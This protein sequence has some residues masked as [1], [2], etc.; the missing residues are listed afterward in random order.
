MRSW[1]LGVHDNAGCQP[2]KIC[3]KIWMVVRGIGAECRISRHGVV[4]R[5][6]IWTFATATTNYS[7][8][9]AIAS[10]NDDQ[11]SL[12]SGTL[13]NN[14][15]NSGATSHCPIRDFLSFERHYSCTFATC[16]VCDCDLKVVYLAFSTAGKRSS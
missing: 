4:R 16:S 5:A 3:V 6:A 1:R 9:F 2:A 12:Q 13:P 11:P 14:D 7:F 10:V 15:T 8:A